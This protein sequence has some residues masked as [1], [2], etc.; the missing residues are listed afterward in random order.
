MADLYVAASGSGFRVL[1]LVLS[2]SHHHGLPRNL[3]THVFFLL[4]QVRISAVKKEL[5]ICY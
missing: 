2:L 1:V 3:V 4:G 5:C